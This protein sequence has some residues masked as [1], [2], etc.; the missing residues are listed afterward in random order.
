MMPSVM[1]S[2]LWDTRLGGCIDLVSA[3]TGEMKK[4][5]GFVYVDADDD[6]NGT[7]DRYKKDS[8][9]WYKR[10]HKNQ[11]TKGTCR[12]I[13]R[14]CI[15]QMTM[16]CQLSHY[17]YAHEIIFQVFAAIFFNSRICLITETTVKSICCMA[18]NTNR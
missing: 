9:Y 17:P 5:Y 14:L 16:A 15:F 3:G 13:A 6:G 7:Y 10:R 8:F 4:R 2:I 12:V 11:R 18:L 1:V